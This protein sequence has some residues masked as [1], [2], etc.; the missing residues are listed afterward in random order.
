MRYSKH[1]YVLITEEF[2][3]GDSVS[4]D[5]IDVDTDT[6]VVSGGSCSELTNMQGIF[7]YKFTP[8]VTTETVYVYAMT[9]GN[10]TKKGKFIFSGYIDTAV[11]N[12]D[13]IVSNDLAT[14]ADVIN[15]NLL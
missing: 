2:N 5:I 11:E 3:P 12:V 8:S 10:Y 14:K 6:L 9:N 13:N 4:I 1:D 7:K 15:A